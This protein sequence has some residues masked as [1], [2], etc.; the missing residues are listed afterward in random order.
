MVVH[1]CDGYYSTIKMN[2]FDTHNGLDDSQML[3]E[4]SQEKKSL[5]HIILFH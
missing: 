2:E 1:A 3:S 5:V 4:R